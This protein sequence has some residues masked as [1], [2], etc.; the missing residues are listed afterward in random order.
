MPPPSRLC[1]PPAP[2]RWA[3]ASCCAVA[4]ST[5]A[6]A[7]PWHEG[8]GDGCVAAWALCFSL[9]LLL[10]AAQAAGRPPPRRDV[11][12]TLAV[13]ACMAC[14]ATAVIWPL[15]HVRGVPPGR[16]RHL[17]VAA[18]AASC[19]ASVAYGAEVLA[20][21][22]RPGEAAPFL[23]TPPGM[24]KVAQGFLGA[25]LLG[26]AAALG[27]G[28][29]PEGWRWCLGIY[30]ASFGAALLLVL[31]CGGLGGLWG[32][33]GVRDPVLAQRLL[34]AYAAL[35]VVAYGAA[36]VL[37]PLY[38]FQEERGGQARRPPGCSPQCP[39]DR[40]A[41]VAAGTAA[42]LL[43]YVADVVQTGR[44]VLLRA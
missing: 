20:T 19:L 33:F 26:V 30:G 38:G 24:L 31:G 2:W 32:C 3:Q 23:A 7:G 36:T 4:F 25:L 12:L 21:R 16:P 14:A 22:G 11:P 18:T 5:A 27:A 17:R 41:L 43:L 40:V 44:L 37:W 29:G 13:A 10:L 9:T 28:S 34:W 6:A 42:N 8:E 15:A 39:W 35:G 1:A